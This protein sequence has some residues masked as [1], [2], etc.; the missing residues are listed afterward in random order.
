L[1]EQAFRTTGTLAA[2]LALIAL[3]YTALYILAP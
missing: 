2:V 3:L 1:I